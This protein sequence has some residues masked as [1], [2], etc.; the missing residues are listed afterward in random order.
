MFSAEAA[1][2][3][4]DPQ[5]QDLVYDTDTFKWQLRTG[6]R[7]DGDGNG[8][9]LTGGAGRDL[10][11]GNGGA[12]TLTG[13]GGADRLDGGAGDD[14]LYGGDGN[15][16]LIGG[17][18]TDRL[19]GGKG[20]DIYVL[21]DTLDTLVESSN[22]GYDTVQLEANFS[23][24]GFTLANR[25][26]NLTASGSTGFS[27]TGN[28]VDNRIEG[29]S[30]ANTISGLDGND[31]LVG[32]GG[33]DNLTGGNGSDVFAWKLADKGVSGAAAADVI[34]D[35]NYG[36]GFSTVESGTLGVAVGG[37]DVLDLR[38]LLQG[39]HTS[40]GV[41]NPVTA[42]VEISDL[43]KFIHVEISGSNTILHINS[44]GG[45]T[46]GSNTGE[47][48]TITLNNVNLYTATA[49][50]AGDDTNLLKMLVKMGTLRID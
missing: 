31:Y 46:A 28:N 14:T 23:G 43:T 39:E 44:S 16:V 2:T 5:I 37:G 17:T 3:L 11:S 45:F 21:S 19:E 27:L 20:D 48:Q 34:T 4:A 10:L 26:E 32:G 25:F 6:S 8:N 38:D 35:F 50:T 29:N 33:N 12:D 40:S 47:D 41:T 22:S 15:D 9:S 24:A 1:P 7:L 30:G 42:S 49:I 13:N 36:G 18:G